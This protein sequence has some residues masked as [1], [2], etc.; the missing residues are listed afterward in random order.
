MTRVSEPAGKA[1]TMAVVTAVSFVLAGCG[2]GQDAPPEAI[3]S[4][5]EYR[6]D[7]DRDSASMALDAVMRDYP[8]NVCPRCEPVTS[9]NSRR[10]A[11]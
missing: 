4:T 1:A 5:Y 9:T 6:L 10:Q 2:G 3:R 11:A 8:E 7:D